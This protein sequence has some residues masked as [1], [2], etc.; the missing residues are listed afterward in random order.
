MGN[1]KRSVLVVLILLLNGCDGKTKSKPVTVST[2]PTV[3][4]FIE[5]MNAHRD[6]IGCPELTWDPDLAGV[7]Q[8]HSEDMDENSYL[9]HTNLQGKTPFDR[10]NDNDILY[11]AAGENI[12]LAGEGAQAVFDAWM[13]SPGHKANIE[14]CSYTHHGVGLEGAYWTHMFM[15]QR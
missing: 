15:V 2:D 5:I 10:M 11:S 3:N 6:D 1:F 8:D 4:S 7:A 12:A 14:N 13:E 9:D